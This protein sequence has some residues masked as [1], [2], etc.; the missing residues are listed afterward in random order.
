MGSII[1]SSHSGI[2]AELA[3]SPRLSGIS[4][5]IAIV[6]WSLVTFT[7]LL[8]L[9]SSIY[10]WNL[11]DRIPAAETHRYFLDVTPENVQLHADWKTTVLQTGLSLSG[12]ASIFT[13]AR[14]IGGLSLLVVGFLLIRHNSNQLMA[15][16]MAT[17]LSVFA[18]PCMRWA[19]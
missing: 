6:L 2:K 17:L 19:M 11:W 9:A 8:S 10:S 15:V 7:S 13:L 3:T 1:S 4:Q 16:L 18:A 12:Y 14:T 5:K